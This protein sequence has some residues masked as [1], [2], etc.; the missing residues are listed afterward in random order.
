MGRYQISCPCHFGLESVLKFETQRLGGEDISCGDGR[1]TFYG[2]ENTI[3]KANLWLRTAER[4]QIVLAQF[5]AKNFEELFQGVRAI[6]WEEYVGKTDRFPVKG[7][8]LHSALHSVPDCQ[9]IVK[10]A[11]VERMKQHYRVGWLEETGPV[12]QVQFAILKNSVT[13]MLDTSGIGLHKRGYRR[14]ANAAPMKETLAAGIADLARVRADSYVYDPFCGSGTLLIESALKALNIAPGIK[15]RF[16]AERWGWLPLTIWNRAREEALDS[17]NR[18]ARFEGIGFD[19]DPAAVELTQQNAS[20]AGVGK[21]IRVSCADVKDFPRVEDKSII[22]C[23]PPYGERMLELRG[24]QALY[25]VMGR[26]LR[27]NPQTGCY[28]IT[29]DEDFE[30]YFGRKASKRRK[31]YN[32]MLRCQLYMYF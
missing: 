22:L 18:D 14:D 29:A 16:L 12:V 23:N 4:V 17:L 27:Q 25:A 26:V 10:K 8:S 19:L 2:D 28:V 24:A 7:Y 11:I 1:V 5:P 13:V 9:S 31:L 21:R 15:R 6:A 32:G 30:T 3:A 20:K